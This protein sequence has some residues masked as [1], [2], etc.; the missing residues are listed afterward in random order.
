MLVVGLKKM[1]VGNKTKAAKGGGV[2]SGLERASKRTN[3]K[4]RGCG[5]RWLR[6]GKK[7]KGN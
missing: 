2:G 3:N 7:R 5:G 1:E 6:I 4:E